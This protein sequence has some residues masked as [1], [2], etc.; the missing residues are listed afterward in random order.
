MN[1]ADI[2]NESLSTSAEKAAFVSGIGKSRREISYAGLAHSIDA[3]VQ[4][5]RLRGLK[6]GDR[7]F[8]AIPVSIET[9]VAMLAILK[10]GLVVMF[11]DPAH[12][13]AEIARCLKASPPAAVVSTRLYEGSTSS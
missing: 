6:P 1:V 13:P 3:L 12:G 11:I 7:V 10:T 4:E 9:Y 2:L 8:L 5:F